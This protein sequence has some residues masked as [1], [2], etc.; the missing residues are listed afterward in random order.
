MDPTGQVSPLHLGLKQPVF[1]SV[2]NDAGCWTKPNNPAVSPE[3][4]KGLR[5]AY[6]EHFYYRVNQAQS[7]LQGRL[8]LLDHQALLVSL[9]L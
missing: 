9:V 6:I 7:A 8:E 4:F 5:L 2:P 3:K 1:V